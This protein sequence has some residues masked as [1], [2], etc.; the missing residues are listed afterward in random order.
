[1]IVWIVLGILLVGV[2]LVALVG[3]ERFPTAGDVFTSLMRSNAGRW[4]VL[5]GWAWFGWHLFV[6]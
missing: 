1:M 3:S 4:F 5:A 6:R 2:E